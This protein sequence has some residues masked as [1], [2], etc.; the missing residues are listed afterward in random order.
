M[1]PRPNAQIAKLY[2]SNNVAEVEF[3]HRALAGRPPG[4][5]GRSTTC[6]ILWL[7]SLRGTGRRSHVDRRRMTRSIKAESE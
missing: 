2:G 5:I 7:A 4:R 3:S 6:L 1:R